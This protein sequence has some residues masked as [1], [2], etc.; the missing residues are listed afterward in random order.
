MSIT[1][2]A[3]KHIDGDL[4]PV[5]D[6]KALDRYL[7]ND[8]DCQEDLPVPNPDYEPML[9]INLATGNAIGI[10]ELV[11]LKLEHDYFEI[12]ISTMIVRCARVLLETK[13]NYYERTKIG[14]I[15]TLCILGAKMGA[16]HIYGC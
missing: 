9:D 7:Y 4:R 1:F 14:E 12:D 10:L 5:Y 13:I 11:D 6:F 16:T 2:Y 15:Q 3:A 8:G